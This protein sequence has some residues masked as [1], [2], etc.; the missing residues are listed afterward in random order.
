VAAEHPV[1]KQH[2]GVPSDFRVTDPDE[3]GDEH[4]AG[5]VPRP[6]KCALLLNVFDRRPEFAGQAAICRI[7]LLKPRLL[8]SMPVDLRE[9]R[10][11]HPAFPQE[12]TADQ[13]FDEAQWESYRC[14]G[15]CIGRRVFGFGEGEIGRALWSYLKSEAP[16]PSPTV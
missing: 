2:F 5:E 13:F 11:P 9:Y 7:V 15:Y 1:L 12:P 3:E 14:L 6:E 10:G 4:D 16:P 8:P